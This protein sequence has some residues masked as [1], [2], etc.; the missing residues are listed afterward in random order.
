MNL[1]PKERWET[2]TQSWNATHTNEK[3]ALF[4]KCLDMNCN[5]TDP[6]IKT[7]GW[8]ELLS[9]ML[10]FHQQLPGARFITTYFLEHSN[11]SIARWE[12]RNADNLLLGDGISYGEYAVTGKLITMTGFFEPP[13]LQA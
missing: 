3:R 5:Y 8:D 13:P 1:K 12:M 4:E 2:Y 6:L 10:E 7:H 11:K 9:Y